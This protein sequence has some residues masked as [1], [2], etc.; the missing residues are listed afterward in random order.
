MGF[1]VGKPSYDD[2]DDDSI[3]ESPASPS[4]LASAGPAIGGLDDDYYEVSDGHML[5]SD[6]GDEPLRSPFGSHNEKSSNGS[7]EEEPFFQDANQE[8]PNGSSPEEDDEESLNGS[9]DEEDDDEES[10]DGSSDE[11][12]PSPEEGEGDEELP[13]GLDGSATYSPSGSSAAE[14]STGSPFATRITLPP[15]LNPTA[16]GQK[17]AEAA[18]ATYEK[19]AKRYDDSKS[20]DTIKNL[21]THVANIANACRNALT[22]SNLVNE[23]G[24][25]TKTGIN[26]KSHVPSK[27]KEAAWAGALGSKLLSPVNRRYTLGRMAPVVQD[28][29]E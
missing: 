16:L 1:F 11:G 21:K 7:P 29:E 9:S 14:E 12:K 3:V 23:Q 25:V 10:P 8:P 5:G 18:G 28:D 13:N 4:S 19:W 26:K 20:P 6:G 24:T 15:N 2:D 27:I 17:F 22:D